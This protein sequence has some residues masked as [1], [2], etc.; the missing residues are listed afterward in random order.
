MIQL[1]N[2][3]QLI[4]L[5]HIFII[6][7][8]LW[9]LATNRFPEEYKQYILWLVAALVVFHAYRFF[10]NAHIEGMKSVSGPQ[11]HHVKMFDS[12]PGY[13]KPRLVVTPGSIVVWTNVGE[14]EHTVTSD[15][16]LF[17][18]GVV[19]PGDS[20]SMKFTQSGTFPYYCLDHR[21]WM[22]GVVIVK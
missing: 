16:D 12:L 18:S 6:A 3:S 22:M 21:G 1:P 7:P 19:R 5:V 11:V 20:F 13:D 14:L 8:F 17:N 10:A 2:Y 15:N 9:A 4:N